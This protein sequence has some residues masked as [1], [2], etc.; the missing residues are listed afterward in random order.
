MQPVLT[1]TSFLLACTLTSI[2]SFVLG[3]I[4]G[5]VDSLSK[6]SVSHNESLGGSGS[7]SKKQRRTVSID[8][9]K[10]VVDVDANFSKTEEHELG[11]KSVT[12]DDIT[13]AKNKLSQLKRGK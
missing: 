13:S 4:A 12:S 1:L 11:E 8:E 9:S 2:F 5:R 3:Y 10:V 6:F 7:A